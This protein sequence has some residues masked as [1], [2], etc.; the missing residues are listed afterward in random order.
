MYS[1]AMKTILQIEGMSCAHCVQHVKEALEAV[2]GVKS[3]DVSLKDKSASVEHS[4]GV[5]IAALRAAVTEAGF[6]AA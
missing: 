4:D 3:A 5:D 6:E 1:K 2:A